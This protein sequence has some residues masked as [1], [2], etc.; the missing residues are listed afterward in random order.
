MPDIGPHCHELRVNDANKTWR[1]IYRIDDDA[2]LVV[3]M[4]EKKTRTTPKQVS[5]NCKRRLRLF[6]EAA[7]DCNMNLAKK[8]RLAAVGW[9]ETRVKEF[10]N[11]SDAD[12]Q[13]IETKLALSRRLRVFRQKRHLTQTKAATILNTSQSR[14]AR[15]EAGDPSVSLD[16]LVRGLFALGAT[17]E[18]LA[19]AV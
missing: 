16:L 12:A 8:R 14:L 15:M 7:G 11:L 9:K 2:L 4:F 5:E 19:E 3:E 10:L 18:D 6:D 1:V 13:Y 17:R